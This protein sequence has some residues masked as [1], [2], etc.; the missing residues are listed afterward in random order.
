MLIRK[1]RHCA[2]SGKALRGLMLATCLSA[3]SAAVLSAQA[4]FAQAAG[5]ATGDAAIRPWGFDL[6]GQN[7]A[8]RPGDNFFDYANGKAVQAITIPAD[9]TSYGAFDRLRE[10]SQQRVRDILTGLAKTPSASP[11][12]SDEKLAAYYTTFMDEAAIET[13]GAKPLAA[14]LAAIRAVKT[15]TDLAHL[16]GT[17]QTTFQTTGFSLGIQPDAKDPTRFSIDVDQ[18][19]LGMPDRDYYLKPQ[20]AA[21]KQAYQA[22]VTKML[23]LVGWPDAAARAADVV[24]LETSVAG[25]HWARA[26]MRDPEKTYNARSVAELTAQ[27]PGFDWTA[28][29]AGA[30]ISVEQAD[31]AKL[32]VGEPSAITGQAKILGAAKL[33]VLQAW[34]A[35][36]L[37]NN[38]ANCLSSSFVN[39]SYDF[40]RKTLAGQPQLAVRWKRGADM[41]ED[42][43]GW[44]IGK[45]YVDRYFPPESKAKMDALT[46]Q[47]KAAFRIRLQN[48]SWM[49]PATKQRAVAKLDHFEIQI[50]YPKKWRTYD[51][52]SIRPGDAYGNAARAGAFEWTYWLG[53]LGKPVDRDEWDMTPQ[54]VNAYNNPVFNEVVFP[55]SILQ[56]PFFDPNADTAVNYGAI[57]GVIGHEMTHGF[58]D[59]GRKFDEHGRLSDWWTKEDAARFEKLGARFAAQYDAFQVLPGVHLNGKLTMGENIADLGGLTLALDAYRASLGGK[60]A[61]T[62][63]GMTGDQRVFL[64]WAQ[65]WRMK[66]RED[67]ARQLATI[68]PHSAPTARVNLP[69]H[70]IDAWY[71]AWNVVPGQTLYLAPDARVKI[72]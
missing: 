16:L 17:G 4:A 26:D 59:E 11:Q 21:K 66:V 38:A 69:M 8:V 5:D 35:F 30:G 52:L 10:L 55:A 32:I 70:N 43:M 53:H 71:K 19:G 58:D 27:A 39:A 46:K 12:T 36:H 2:L 64:G 9:R 29:L 1:F 33:P 60:P 7:K 50:G 22:Y 54:T 25:V 41:T 67:R 48:N 28:W 42:A 68:D 24:A 14:D 18:S 49:S 31:A 23:G 45:I 6:A 40:N 34:L 72:W 47:L 57:G 51:G 65:V 3:P 13:L 37:A 56:P 20:F 15:P 62:R 63:D 44:S 61:G